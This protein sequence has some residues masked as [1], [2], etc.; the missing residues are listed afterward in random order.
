MRY[1]VIPDGMRAGIHERFGV[2]SSCPPGFSF[3][4]LGRAS[5]SALAFCRHARPKG[6]HDEGMGGHNQGKRPAMTKEWAGMPAGNRDP[7]ASQR[8]RRL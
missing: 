2:L 4:F 7:Y 1:G 8:L 6:G 5:T 3:G